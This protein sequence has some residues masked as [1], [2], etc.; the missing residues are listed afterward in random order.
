MEIDT[1]DLFSAAHSHEFILCTLTSCVSTL[2]I[3][4][5][6]TEASMTKAREHQKCLGINISIYSAVCKMQWKV[7][8]FS[9]T[10]TG[11]PHP[12]RL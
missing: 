2:T 8:L 12:Q 11:A 7:H 10:T 3:T 5:T 4:T 1:S 6:T 9:K